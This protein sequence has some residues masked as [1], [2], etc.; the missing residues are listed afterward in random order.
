MD[1]INSIAKENN[2]YVI[3][4]CAQAHGALYKNRKIGNLGNISAFSFYP[5]KNL[6]AFGD[7]GA[8]CTDNDDLAKKCRMISN[9]GRINKFDHEFEGRN[10]R[11]DTI[12]AAVLNVKL[13]YLDSWIKIR[14][15]N[16]K[17]YSILLKNNTDIQC[18]IVSSKMYHAFHL[19]VIQTDRREDL[20]EYLKKN[21]IQTGIHYPIALSKLQAYKYLNQYNED[22][23]A[24]KIDSRL[25][26]LPIGE[27]LMEKDIDYICK[28]INDFFN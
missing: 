26:S 27:H 3:E 13:K 25:L 24:N 1:E 11:L 16:A 23:I 10:S 22:M 9:H 28:K 14:N 6:G 21:S 12:H 5:G 2:L 8:I 20:M 4:D 17:Q 19:Y 15:K 18:P 7:A